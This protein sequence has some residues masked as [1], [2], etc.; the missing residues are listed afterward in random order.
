MCNIPLIIRINWFRNL[1]ELAKMGNNLQ[2]NFETEIQREQKARLDTTDPISNAFGFIPI[3]M[4]TAA[5]RKHKR[6]TFA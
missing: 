4:L 3:C 2:I 1:H 5:L 6:L